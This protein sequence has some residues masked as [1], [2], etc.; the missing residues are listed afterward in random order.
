MYYINVRT[1]IYVPPSAVVAITS[2]DRFPVNTKP[3]CNVTYIADTC[4][5]YVT[6]PFKLGS[7]PVFLVKFRTN[8]SSPPSNLFLLPVKIES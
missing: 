3:L 8:S 7:V 1:Y 2:A 5:L 6:D 4:M